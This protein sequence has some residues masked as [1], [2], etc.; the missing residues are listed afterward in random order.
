LRKQYGE[1]E[2]LILSEIS[3]KGGIYESIRTFLGK[4]K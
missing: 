3:D 4:G 2:E 1:H